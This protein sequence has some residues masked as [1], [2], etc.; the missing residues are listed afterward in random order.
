M[1]HDPA[2]TRM[3]TP[4]VLADTIKPTAPASAAPAA[5]AVGA[6]PVAKATTM[7]S[8]MSELLRISKA[9][10]AAAF[11]GVDAPTNISVTDRDGADYQNNSAL[12]IFGKLKGMG[13]LPDGV[14][15]SKDVAEALVAKMLEA[16]AEGIIKKL[17]VAGPGFIN[18]FLSVEWLAAR[19][20]ALIVDG[21][22]PPPA[23]KKEVVVDF[24]SPNVA[25]EMH[26][27]HLRS[28]IIG[29]TICRL[30]E[31]CGHHVHRVNHVG[32]WGTQ[33]GMLIG[34]L[35]NVFPDYATKPPPIADL[36]QFYRDAKKAFDD[37]EDF[38]KVAH[39]EVVRLQGG[40]GA[41]RFAWR[42]ICEV[43]RREF[44]KIYSRL[45]VS[46]HEVGESYYN[47]Y[48]PAVVNHLEEIGLVSVSG[49]AKV[50]FPPN[51]KH[52][53]PL[54]VVKSDGGYGYDSTDM[55]AIWY[56]LFE[57]KADWLVYVTDAGQGPHFE[58]IFEAAR[59]AGWVGAQRLDHTPFGM[60]CGEDGKKYKTRSGDVVRLVDLLDEAVERMYQGMKER[61][62]EALAQSSEGGKANVASMSDEQMR[63]AARVLGYGAVKY[64]DLKGNRVSDYR[65]SYD[66]MLDPK[67]NTAVYLL[68]AGARISS[69]LRNAPVTPDE[70]LARGAPLV[71]SNEH[72]LE[73]ARAMLRFPEVL[74][75]AVHTLLPNTLCEYVY[76]LCV[77][78]S[79]FW[80]NCKV[81]GV[82]EQ[83]SRIL[84]IA[85]LERV[86]RKSFELLGLGYL[87]RI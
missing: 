74:E 47:E 37:S 27:G 15:N 61:A 20:Q 46:L 63:E 86:M 4:A 84:I 5:S 79:K 83:D 34:H 25:K 9:A 22:L 3:A 44:E 1:Y 24:S 29:D 49:G 53:N 32:D 72:E 48:I 68:Y 45:E 56:R 21:V 39:E 73:L 66:R 40:D 60:V 82:P 30:L 14:K 11:P 17:V 18:I 78:F 13:A 26:V 62:A 41:S 52:E 28:T 69:V 31:F 58:L 19:V 80:N 7:G 57:L 59:A 6:T 64:A 77:T 55:A 65:F 10:L 54:M 38:K 70:L 35:K 42:A 87:E 85:G 23:E 43:S 33:F 71:L 2:V 50:I 76:N 75:E 36:Q 12:P 51:T 16:D 81:I 8:V 67:G